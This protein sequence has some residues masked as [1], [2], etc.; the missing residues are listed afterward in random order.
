[1]EKYF[2]LLHSKKAVQLLFLF[3]QSIPLSQHDQFLEVREVGP[4]IPSGIDYFVR[5][6]DVFKAALEV[7]ECVLIIYTIYPHHIYVMCIYKHFSSFLLKSI[8]DLKHK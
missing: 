5:P 7:V 4:V 1:V 3:P 2:I 6:A 8:A